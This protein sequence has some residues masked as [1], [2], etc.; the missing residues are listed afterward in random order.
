MS[1]EEALRV[2]GSSTE[3][4]SEE[5]AG[6]RLAEYARWRS[7]ESRRR[8]RLRSSRGRE[9]GEARRGLGAHVHP[10]LEEAH[11]VP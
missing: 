7:W 1:V 8:R 10:G 5:E 6:R 9:L 11:A 3:G 4:L 2:L